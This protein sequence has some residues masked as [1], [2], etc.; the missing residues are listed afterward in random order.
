MLITAKEYAAQKGL[1][2][3]TVRLHLVEGK[4]SGRK[5]ADPLTGVEVWMVEIPDDPGLEET[6]PPLPEGIPTSQEEDPGGVGDIP[7][8]EGGSW[9]EMAQRL[10][11]DNLE[12]AG[13]CG[14]YQAKIQDLETKMAL[15]E[16]P[17]VEV[18]KKPW[19]RF[20]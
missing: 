17:K 10:Y 14:F 6:I 9:K 5:V 12:L 19:W 11:Q 15:L 8:G 3:R 2:H 1:H 7:D 13:R 4:I 18:T 16:A 20:W